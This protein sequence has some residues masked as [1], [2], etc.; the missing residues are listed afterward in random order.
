MASRLSTLDD[1]IE[2]AG[3]GSPP[4][5]VI[6][7]ATERGVVEGAV[8]A[9]QRNIIVPT[10]VGPLTEV[11]AAVA[12]VP[13]A[14]D[15]PIIDVDDA[16]QASRQAVELVVGKEADILCKG[17]LHTD[18]FLHP[19]LRR[20]RG[21]RRLSHVFLAELPGSPKLLSITD[22]VINVAP[23]LMEKAAIIRNAIEFA[24]LTGL[25]EPK[26]AVLSAVEVVSAV[27][28]S[29][30]DAAALAA[31]NQ[32]GELTGALVDGPLAL[33]DAVS[34]E[35]AAVKGITSAVAGDADVLVAPDLEAGNIL[36]KSLEHLAGA[37]LAGMVLG[38]TVPIVLTSTAESLRSRL[39]S[40]GVAAV[41]HHRRAAE[42]PLGA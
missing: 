1:F 4:R 11:Q 12:S 17:H 22:G 33:D 8:A 16:A 20:L 23:D 10:F 14:T 36:A 35:A 40:F 32:R 28:P 3:R 21:T 37:T 25:D 39:A 18:V 5:A 13:G 19:I 15:I 2:E 31:M 34:P 7:E 24:R 6:V 29:T 26:V 27:I 41:V 42:P 9:A 30:A 38:A